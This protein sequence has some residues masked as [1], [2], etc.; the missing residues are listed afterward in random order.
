MQAINDNNN[1]NDEDD[2]NVARSIRS[3]LYAPPREFQGFDPSSV[4]AELLTSASSPFEVGRGSVLDEVLRHYELWAVR[5][6]RV[7][8][9]DADKRGGHCCEIF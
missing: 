2:D 3:S 1:D 7:A 6:D 8:G 9:D 5:Q 4:P